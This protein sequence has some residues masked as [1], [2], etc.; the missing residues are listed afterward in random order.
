MAVREA[1]RGF[2]HVSGRRPSRYVR[3]EGVSKQA[4]EI[5]RLRL[6]VAGMCFLLAFAVVGGRMVELAFIGDPELAR[7]VRGR[8]SAQL[9][10]RADVVDRN[11]VVLATSLPTS[12]LFAHPN[13][14]DDKP[15]AA[16]SLAVAVPGLRETD[17]LEK[18]ESGRRFV[19]L[20]RNLTPDEKYAVNRLGVP[21]FEFQDGERRVYPH[22]R[23]AAHILGFT[24]VDGR[25][26]SGVEG[27]FDAG[28]RNRVD[29]L[30]LSID[31]RVQNVLREELGK[32]MLEFHAI[33]AA[34]L[35]MDVNTGEVLGLVSL[36]DF[37]PNHPAATP[38]EWRFNRA[39]HGVY[40]MGSTFKLFTAAMALD[41]GTV[42]LDDGYDASE[43]IRVAGFT[44]HDFHGR[45]RWLSIPEI[46]VYS[47]NIGAAKMAMDVG[48]ELQKTYLDRLGLLRAARVEL[49]EVGGPLSPKIWRPINT[50]TISYG[51]GIAVSPLQVTTAVSSVVNG[52][53]WTPATIL[54]RGD[55]GAPRARVFRAK[56]SEQMRKLM[57][58]VVREG[59]GR[60]ARAKGYLVGGKTGTANKQVDGRY[61]SKARISSFVG[62][63]PIDNPRYVVFALLDEPK[64]NK[65]TWNYAGGGWVAAPVVGGVV[66][67]VGPLMGLKPLGEDRIEAFERDVLPVTERRLAAW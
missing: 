7:R 48:T 67:R 47:S 28:L 3:L 61:S 24:D 57:R 55:L 32:A 44:I 26:L 46:L 54:R 17:V 30:A 45:K 40:E 15:R 52:G 62:A 22:G 31:I 8:V 5:G 42:G 10:E 2:G 66:A 12:S 49:K 51:H 50:M 6:I 59:S 4:L 36:P 58:L 29:P 64:G 63:F 20:R 35:I 27:F 1:E 56:T 38:K 9:A 14:I 60:R 43:P 65:E 19:W 53:W 21:G 23:L 41:T 16:R 18:L 33:G 34:G 25:G 39:T 13:D 11:G 37:D